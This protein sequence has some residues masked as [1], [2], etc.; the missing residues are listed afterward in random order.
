MKKLL[1][2]SKFLWMAAFCTAVALAS[3][4]QPTQGNPTLTSGSGGIL[5]PPG[6]G[7]L[8]GVYTP[9][10]LPF[11][12]PIPYVYEREADIMWQ[13]RIWRTI[14]L[15]EKI[16]HPLYYPD[17]DLAKR[18]SLFRILQKGIYTGKINTVFDF[19]PSTMEFG[20]T[21]TVPEIVKTMTEQLA[22]KDSAGNPLMDSLGNQVYK[23]DT[24]RPDKVLQY[25]IKEDWFFDKQRSVM[26]VRIIGI[27]PLIESS[28]PVSGKFGYKPLFWLY[29]PAIRN[30]LAQSYC[31]NPYNDAEWRTF[32]EV[33]QK[34]L[35]SSYISME[36]NVYNR[37]VTAYLPGQGMDQLL[38]S[39]RIKDD[40]FKFEHDMWHF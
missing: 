26:D 22:M 1:N 8:D 39:E 28:D 33:F 36:S 25:L 29:Y 18:P 2:A 3:A 20:S 15:R 27:A 11:R 9:E 4:Q 13:K 23:P 35:F 14:D 34:R 31:Y 10:H 38:E 24:I 17:D 7:V 30:I 32:D 12:K 6:G 21:L 40:I 5:E 16:N 19:D 37:T